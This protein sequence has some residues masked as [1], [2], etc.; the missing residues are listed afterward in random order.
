M[1]RLSAA[2]VRLHEHQPAKLRIWSRWALIGAI[3]ATLLPVLPA[4]PAHAADETKDQELERFEQVYR[5]VQ[6]LHVSAPS[7]KSLTEAA[8]KGMIDSLNDP[9]TKYMNTKEWNQFLDSLKNN[10]VGIGIR[11]GQDERG[12]YIVEVFAGSPAEKAG[13]LPGDYITG[14]NGASTEGKPTTQLVNEIVG[15]ENT[16]VTVSIKRGDQTFDATMQRKP[17][18]LPTVVSHQFD[19]GI[20][21]IRVTSFSNDSDELLAGVLDGWR[22][23]GLKSLVL[24]LRGNPGGL[25][26]TAKH[27]AEQFI[28]EG[29]LIHTSNRDGKDEPV[30]IE[31]GKAA[32]FPVY[33]LV[34][35]DSASASEV[36]AGALQDY[37][38]ATVMGTKTYGK[39]SVQSI[40]ELDGGVLKVTVEEYFTPNGRK[41]NHEGIMP[42]IQVEGGLNQLISGLR[43]AG[44]EE[45]MLEKDRAE[46]KL[47]GF[48]L[49]DYLPLIQQDDKTF[50]HSRVLASLIG[51]DVS[52]NGDAQSV[53]VTDADGKQA[54]FALDS[55]DVRSEEGLTLIDVSAFAAAFPQL[56]WSVSGKD[57]TLSSKKRG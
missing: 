17:I 29:V 1:K 40:I 49:D 31:N 16:D 25:V 48:R 27:I 22:T 32:D 33:V 9:Y 35:Q 28:K 23:Q 55:S 14:V 30:L 15:E 45:F 7:G 50:V 38:V 8:I 10:Y 34:D 13:L 46:Y 6:Q 18:A 26:D 2:K 41:V 24:D 54:I 36:L 4:M 20:G 12:T 52:W 42:D 3:T 21:Y 37:K 5:T 19:G 43:Q 53:T 57:V 56:E 11:I 39:G 47:N 44:M 51:A